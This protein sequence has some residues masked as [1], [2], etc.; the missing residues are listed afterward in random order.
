LRKAVFFDRDGVINIDYG[1]VGQID[2]FD[3]IRGVPQALHSFKELGYLLILVTNQSGIARGRYTEAD[4]HRVTAFMQANL[5]LYDACFDG[6]YFC[7]H[8]P[9]ADLPQYREN[10]ACRKPKSGMLIKA[11]SDFNIS[12]RDSIL[13]GDHASDL[14]AGRNAGVTRLFLVGDHQESEKLKINDII[15]EQ[16]LVNIVKIL[17]NENK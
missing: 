14:I 2:K 11:A 6:I 4:F 7:P 9:N 12:L 17:K 8:H 16:S 15:C 10:C 1:F 13:I 3:I 5:S